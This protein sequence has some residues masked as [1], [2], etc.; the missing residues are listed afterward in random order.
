MFIEINLKMY[1][2]LYIQW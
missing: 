1:W 2:C